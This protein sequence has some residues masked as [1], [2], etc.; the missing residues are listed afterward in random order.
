MIARN[1]SLVLEEYFHGNERDRAHSI[2]SITKSVNS[3]LVGKALDEGL[4]E[5]VEE[6]VHSFFKDRPESKW[7]AG[8]YPITLRHLL[9]M[10]GAIEWNENLPYSNPSNSATAMNESGDW[11]G[12]VL[13]RE[14]AGTPGE[15][16]VYS[17]GQAM[18]LGGVVR[19]VTGRYSAEYAKDTVFEDLGIVRSWWS[20]APDGTQHTGG[21]LM[22]T[23]RDLLKIGE[24]MRTGG[25]WDGRRVI[26]EAWVRASI[27]PL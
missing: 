12:Y 9:L 4:I 26:S 6:P 10:S 22:L 3:L 24:V 20:A 2:Q 16:S 27:W 7:V 25:M 21:G 17:S 13:D 19:S 8:A 5:S 14:Q 15:L 23:A 1:G 11:I 18:L